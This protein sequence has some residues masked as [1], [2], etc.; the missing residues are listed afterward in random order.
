MARM[1]PPEFDNINKSEAEKH[2]YYKLNET[3]DD[4]WI[5][6]HSYSLEGRN[7]E[8]KLIDAEIDFLFLNKNYGILIL[9]VKGGQVKCEEGIWYQNSI[10]IKLDA[11][12]FFWIRF[13]SNISMSHLI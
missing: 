11:V 12:L 5:I 3:F 10:K 8:N 2:L 9:E 4:N 13:Y 6:F 7:K 1:I